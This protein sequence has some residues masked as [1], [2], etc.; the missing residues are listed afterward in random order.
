MP[1]TPS[2]Q[3]ITLA[4]AILGSDS[5]EAARV[6]VAD[7]YAAF[8]RA[9]ASLLRVKSRQVEAWLH[10]G[11]RLNAVEKRLVWLLWTLRFEPH[12]LRTWFDVL[13]WGKF[14]K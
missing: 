12:K 5:D 1:R 13:T 9:T 11:R 14:S 10:H 8:G 4:R 3:A 2:D 7:L 6:R